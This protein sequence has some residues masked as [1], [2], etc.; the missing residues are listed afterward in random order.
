MQL[1]SMGCGHPFMVSLQ[2]KV[3][4]DFLLGNR[5]FGLPVLSDGPRRY[6]YRD[7]SPTPDRQSEVRRLLTW[8]TLTESRLARVIVAG[9]DCMR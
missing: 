3:G 4:F 8:L 1:S 7:H 6:C 9:C 5:P 2:G